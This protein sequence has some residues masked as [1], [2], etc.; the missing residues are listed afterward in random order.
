MKFWFIPAALLVLSATGMGQAAPPAVAG[1]LPQVQQEF[2]AS[3]E[4]LRPAL[5][6]VIALGNRGPVPVGTGF[7]VDA[8]GTFLTAAHVLDRQ[9]GISGFRAYI[10]GSSADRLLAFDILSLDPTRDF[11]LCR[12]SAPQK[13]EPGPRSD[14]LPLEKTDPPAPG[15]MVAIAGFPLGGPKPVF[16]FGTVAA[17]AE[18][19]ELLQVG[20]MLNDGDSGGPVIEVGTGRLVGM[21]ISIRTTALY[22]QA[23]PILGQQ[24]TGLSWVLPVNV[25]TSVLPAPASGE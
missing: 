7:F 19:G 1:G 25:I 10:P 2:R 16:Q 15:V 24:N 6:A 8:R 22:E 4:K 3:V 12:L 5:L 20:L 11:A 9:P 14:F 21:A 17:F 18:P 23:H 13:N